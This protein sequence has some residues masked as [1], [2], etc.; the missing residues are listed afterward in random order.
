MFMVSCSPVDVPLLGVMLV[1]QLLVSVSVYD[2]V[3]VPLFHIWK[4]DPAAGFC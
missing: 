4:L 2:S 3:P 1:I